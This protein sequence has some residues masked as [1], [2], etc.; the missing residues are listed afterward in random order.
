VLIY[1][2]M[3]VL[4]NLAADLLLCLVD[5]RVKLYGRD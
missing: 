3:I 1:C 2:V 4:F 5:P